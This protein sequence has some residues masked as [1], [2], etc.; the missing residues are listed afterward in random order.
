MI[1]PTTRFS[2]TEHGKRTEDGP[3]RHS[4][5]RPDPVAALCQALRVG[6]PSLRTSRGMTA[7]LA[8]LHLVA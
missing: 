7:S 8:A 2:L 3:G 1:A 4:L 6:S 5:A